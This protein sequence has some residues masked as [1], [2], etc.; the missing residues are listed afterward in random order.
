MADTLTDGD[1]PG[2]GDL[3]TWHCTACHR[4]FEADPILPGPCPHCGGNR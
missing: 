4:D 3:V 1:E 2:W